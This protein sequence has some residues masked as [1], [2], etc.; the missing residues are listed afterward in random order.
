M[1]KGIFNQSGE[2]SKNEG[3]TCQP[4]FQQRVGFD[5]VKKQEVDETSV[6]EK[7]SVLTNENEESSFGKVFEKLS[8]VVSV[9]ELNEQTEKVVELAVEENLMVIE[10]VNLEREQSVETFEVQEERQESIVKNEVKSSSIETPSIESKGKNESVK[11]IKFDECRFNLEVD[12]W[13]LFMLTEA[14]KLLIKDN[15]SRFYQLALDE[16]IQIRQENQ[17]L[18]FLIQQFEIKRLGKKRALKQMMNR[19]Y[20]QLDEAQTEQDLDLVLTHLTRLAEVFE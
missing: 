15:E 1:L 20:L 4:T 12:E 19:L 18:A 17:R 9:E 5:K 11:E 14:L 16:E 10:E 6:S 7:I 8:E 3:V 13:E 2:P